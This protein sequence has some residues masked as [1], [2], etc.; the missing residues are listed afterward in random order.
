MADDPRELIRR[1]A[2][3]VG[4]ELRNPLAVINNSAYFVRAKIGKSLDA[5]VE[6]HLRIIES[7]IARADGLIGKMLAFSRPYQPM[8]ETAAFDALVEAVVK[9]YSTPLGGKVN[10][11]LGAKDAK[12]KVEPPAFRDDLKRLLDNAFDAMEGKGS[13]KVITG[14]DKAGVFAA[15][16]D[17][18]PGVDAKIKKSLFEP[19]ITNKPRGL[20]LS[21]ALARK[22]LGAVGGLLSCESG[23]KGAT[24]R[25][26]LPKA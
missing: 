10:V 22:R 15:V 12:V 9:A 13:V 6:K 24:F 8:V 5:K 20:G 25:L 16:S 3:V 2:S 26:V 4:H 1:I 23:P 7:E 14:E 11:Q 18:G 21:L 19:F 17:S